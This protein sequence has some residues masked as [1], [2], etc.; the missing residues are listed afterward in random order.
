MCF[1]AFPIGPFWPHPKIAKL[2]FFARISWKI[3]HILYWSNKF[4]EKMAFLRFSDDTR[5]VPSKNRQINIFWTDFL[6]F[7]YNLYSHHLVTVI[8]ALTATSRVLYQ[9]SLYIIPARK[10]NPSKN[11]CFD[12][13]RIGPF[14]SNPKTVKLMFFARISWKVHMGPE[15]NP[16]KKCILRFLDGT[17]SSHWRNGGGHRGIVKSWIRCISD[18]I[19]GW[20]TAH[21]LKNNVGGIF[22]WK[23][24]FRPKFGATKVRSLFF[25]VRNGGLLFWGIYC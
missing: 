4:V 11:R 21:T 12:V 14:W 15:K 7:S 13:F 23:I 10:K 20:K 2:I 3:T 1:E 17:G 22:W 9:K 24:L 6:I 5:L 8:Q 16:S 19:L 25:K 18:G